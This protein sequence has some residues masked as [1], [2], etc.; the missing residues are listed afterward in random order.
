MATALLT[1]VP[2][3][4]ASARTG[5]SRAGELL[6]IVA[7]ALFGLAITCSVLCLYWQEVRP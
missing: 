3:L 7:R 5:L 6:P 1:A 2:P 4:A